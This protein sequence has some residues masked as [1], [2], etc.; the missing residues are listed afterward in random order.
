VIVKML[1]REALLAV[2]DMRRGR[3]AAPCRVG[4]ALPIEVRACVHA[5]VNACVHACLNACLRACMRVF[6]RK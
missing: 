3:A 6:V 4:L 2:S 1:A 5:C